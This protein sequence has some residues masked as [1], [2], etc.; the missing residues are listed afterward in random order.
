MSL[1]VGGG[2]IPVS[3]MA[4]VL[5]FSWQVNY[6]NRLRG[7]KNVI[8]IYNGWTSQSTFHYM[9]SQGMCSNVNSYHIEQVI[10]PLVSFT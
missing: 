10:I 1:S 2:E 6:K 5:K 8:N 9:F 4:P 7:Q 3:V